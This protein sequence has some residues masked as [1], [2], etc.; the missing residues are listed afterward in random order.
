M[1]Y[2]STFLHFDAANGRISQKFSRPSIRREHLSHERTKGVHYEK[3]FDVNLSRVDSIPDKA[4]VRDSMLAYSRKMRSIQ[5]NRLSD[6]GRQDDPLFVR[7]KHIPKYPSKPPKK[8]R[9]MSFDE[10]LGRDRDV[11]PEKSNGAK[12]RPVSER[13]KPQHAKDAKSDN[14]IH[15]PLLSERLKKSGKNVHV[16]LVSASDLYDIVD[17]SLRS[18]GTRNDSLQLLRLEQDMTNSNALNQSPRRNGKGVTKYSEHDYDVVM[19]NDAYG[20]FE[21][22]Q[23]PAGRSR[24]EKNSFSKSRNNS[25]NDSKPVLS[26][27]V[28]KEILGLGKHE[29]LS[30]PLKL[31]SINNDAF[32]RRPSRAK[33]MRLVDSGL[34]DIPEDNVAEISN[35]MH[36][37][38]R[39]KQRVASPP[40]ILSPTRPTESASSLEAID[41][42]TET[43]IKDETDSSSVS[44]NKLDGYAIPQQGFDD[45]ERYQYRE[46]FSGLDD[47]KSTKKVI[48]DDGDVRIEVTQC[49]PKHETISAKLK[50][51]KRFRKLIYLRD[52]PR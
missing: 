7:A 37:K 49:P 3:Q 28:Y 10:L 45:A 52:A 38:S 23:H 12:V 13:I 30:S 33:R 9:P 4:S 35:S 51:Q 47:G 19:P 31:P 41:E 5:D 34:G 42:N 17:F 44:V 29:E 20:N 43:L 25:T 50:A 11:A 22:T 46:P 48:R 14:E 36:F 24:T 15:L 2:G 6:N 27:E 16:S 21:R 18:K 40:P 32:K 8:R 26:E 39:E 1:S